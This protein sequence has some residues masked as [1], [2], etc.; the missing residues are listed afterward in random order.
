M[1]CE[2]LVKQ[3]DDDECLLKEEEEKTMVQPHHHH[4]DDTKSTDEPSYNIFR[5]SPRKCK[6]VSM[7]MCQKMMMF[8]V[9]YPLTYRISII[10]H[11]Y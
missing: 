2:V 11:T 3:A 7:K 1:N 4:H 6:V 9:Y 5:D 10:I 8:D